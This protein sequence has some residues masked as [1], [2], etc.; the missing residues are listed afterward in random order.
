MTQQRYTPAAVSVGEWRSRLERFVPRDPQTRQITGH[1]LDPNETDFLAMVAA[2]QAFSAQFVGG[3]E[4]H[5]ELW[6]MWAQSVL[7]KA[8]LPAAED[9]GEERRGDGINSWAVTIPDTP[10]NRLERVVRRVP[11]G[12]AEW[13]AAALER[14]CLFLEA[15]TEA[16]D[17]AS[18]A[19]RAAE[20]IGDLLR[21]ADT[22]TLLPGA[23]ATMHRRRE[24]SKAGKA[25]R[26]QVKKRHFE[27]ARAYADYLRKH[28][29]SKE[30]AYAYVARTH[31]R[32]DGKPFHPSTVKKALRAR[33]LGN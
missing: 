32:L 13:F 29:G 18:W 8:G 26:P 28:P 3:S 22:Q 6:R 14:S 10:L 25:E 27:W 31:Y 21:A 23:R 5:R 15:S 11:A 9:C 24:A 19:A 7:T 4:S 33:K 20:I 30:A 17:L 2:E 12:S 1:V 16:T